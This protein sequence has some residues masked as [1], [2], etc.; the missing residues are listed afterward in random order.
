M[1][2]DLGRNDEGDIIF[3]PLAK[4]ASAPWFDLSK[5]FKSN[6]SPIEITNPSDNL[7]PRFLKLITLSDIERIKF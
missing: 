4:S 1:I 2:K 5:I 6:L 7:N 3:P